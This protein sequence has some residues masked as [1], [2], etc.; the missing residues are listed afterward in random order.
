MYFKASVGAFALKFS[1]FFRCI[2]CHTALPAMLVALSWQD[3]AAGAVVTVEVLGAM[4]I[5]FQQ[6]LMNAHIGK[7]D[8]KKDRCKR[9]R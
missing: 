8:D 1:C 4:H 6:Q 9:S 2:P 3:K 5:G 7:I